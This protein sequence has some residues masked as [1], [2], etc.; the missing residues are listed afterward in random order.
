MNLFYPKTY[1]EEISG[2]K[3]LQQL[4]NKLSNK[5]ITNMMKELSTI[6]CVTTEKLSKRIIKLFK[7]PE[8]E[9]KYT[10]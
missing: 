10:D 6:S 5:K 2:L 8:P 9:L 3:Q 1:Q 7:E 4:M